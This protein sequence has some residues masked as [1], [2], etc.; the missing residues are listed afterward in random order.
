MK[1][2]T[3]FRNF[4]CI[5]AL[6]LIA[7]ACSP[8]SE[9]SSKPPAEKVVETRIDPAPG[10]YE[11]TLAQSK[12]KRNCL[13]PGRGAALPDMLIKGLADSYGNCTIHKQPREI[14]ALSGE[15]RCMADPKMAQ[16][17]IRYVYTG[18]V[19]EDAVTLDVKFKFDAAQIDETKMSEKQIAQ[20]K[21][22]MKM[23]EKVKIPA[24]AIRVGD[25]G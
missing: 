19:A 8:A 2:L 20:L 6:V 16:G 25:C 9:T 22:G 23:L 15:V 12:A 17:K 18:T 14:N 4:T 21:L 1:N 5:G 11:F 10:L 13:M 24:Q 3:G 7:T